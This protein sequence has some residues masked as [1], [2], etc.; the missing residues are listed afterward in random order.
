MNNDIKSNENTAASIQKAQLSDYAAG[1]KELDTTSGTSV[2]C[3]A[4]R[5]YCNM[6]TLCAA[7]MFYCDENRDVL[8]F[9]M[10][11][12]YVSYMFLE[13]KS[14]AGDLSNPSIVLCGTPE[15]TG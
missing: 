9:Q 11:S 1:F 12:L 5:Q 13:V 3:N 14:I 4:L 15:E 6:D 2:Q 10:S 8:P 7:C